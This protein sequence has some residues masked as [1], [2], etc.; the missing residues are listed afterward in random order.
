M[1]ALLHTPALPLF[2]SYD[3]TH[4]YVLIY[5]SARIYGGRNVEGTNMGVE[6]PNVVLYILGGPRGSY[7]WVLLSYLYPHFIFCHPAGSCATLILSLAFAVL[8]GIESLRLGFRSPPPHGPW[9]PFRIAQGKKPAS[10]CQAPSCTVRGERTGEEHRERGRNRVE[11]CTS[12]WRWREL[13]FE[14][15][16]TMIFRPC[17]ISR[18]KSIPGRAITFERWR[19]C[20]V[21]DTT[22]ISR[23]DVEVSAWIVFQWFFQIYRYLCC[24]F[25]H[26]GS[27]RGECTRIIK[28]RACACITLV[29]VGG[30]ADGKSL[31]NI[32]FLLDVSLM[33]RIS[34]HRLGVKKS[35]EN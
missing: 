30:T 20:D 25:R 33:V 6:R 23:R 5:T 16:G 11:V 31:P 10:P 29:D 32:L 19:F 27:G 26:D 28:E 17:S 22:V 1:K 12:G 9:S 21:N 2:H 34:V 24:S 18:G 3:R 13:F 35:L 8:L 14:S 7:G 4:T 15:S